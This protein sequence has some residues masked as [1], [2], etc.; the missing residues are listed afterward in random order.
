MAAAGPL[1]ERGS[2]V[3]SHIMGWMCYSEERKSRFDGNVQGGV[4]F[5]S[6]NKKF[7]ILTFVRSPKSQDFAIQAGIER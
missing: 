4:H 7:K 2:A 3:T 5:V 1:R 6:S